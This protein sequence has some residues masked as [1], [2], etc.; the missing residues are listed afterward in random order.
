[1]MEQYE[2]AIPAF[3][4]SIRWPD[5]IYG[6]I[7]LTAPYGLRGVRKKPVRKPKRFLA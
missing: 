4:K 6:R 3:E 1:M 7:G 2:E 5:Y